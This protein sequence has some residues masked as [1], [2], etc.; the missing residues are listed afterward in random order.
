MTKASAS[1][2]RVTGCLV[3]DAQGIWVVGRWGIFWRWG[4]LK[5]FEETNHEK[6]F[7]DRGQRRRELGKFSSPILRAVGL[8]RDLV[9]WFSLIRI[10][11]GGARRGIFSG[12]EANL[13]DA[14]V[15]FMLRHVV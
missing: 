4:W 5:L 3:V 7:I 11:I 14:D 13:I 6:L 9:D 1:L 2:G 12:G 10:I 15:L 8:G